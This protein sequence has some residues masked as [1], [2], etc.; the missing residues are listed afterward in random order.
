MNV[1]A[2]IAAVGGPLEWNTTWKIVLIVVNAVALAAALAALICLFVARRKWK[3]SVT[4]KEQP[5]VPLLLLPPKPEQWLL[6]E[7]PAA[8]PICAEEEIAAAVAEADEDDEDE[9]DSPASFDEAE[10]ETETAVVIV[11][12]KK[13]YYRYNFSFRAKLIQSPVEIQQRYGILMDEV[14]ACPKVKT[15]LSWRQV[16]IYS[17]RQTL[18]CIL[19]R[20]RKLCISFALD[21]AVYADTKYRG[22]DL[23]EVKRYQ[24]TPMLLK[25]TSE[26]KVNYAKYLFGEVLK[27]FGLGKGETEHSEFILPFQPTEELIVEGLVKVMSNEM[28]TKD[29]EA[30]KANISELI[31][32]KITLKEAR[33]VLTNEAAATLIEEAAE[34]SQFADA[35]LAKQTE[36][37]RTGNRKKGIVNIDTLSCNF[38]PNETVTL[39]KMQEKG[40]V[41]KNIQSVKVLAR[42][43]LSKPLVVEAQDFSIDAVKMIVLT[44]GRA[45]KKL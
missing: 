27:K 41:P 28:L 32:E 30:V 29:T 44:G 25:L 38:A 14:R 22:I 7:P 33:I 11:G 42:G 4:K 10:E 20:G 12:D 1:Q 9:D 31:R 43:I 13:I 6:P 37:K 24:K 45:V 5:A 18:A 26:R 40:L 23:S 34:E 17:G 39:Q 19:F 15:N 3:T 2:L 8:T 21:P 35:L 16:R 36:E